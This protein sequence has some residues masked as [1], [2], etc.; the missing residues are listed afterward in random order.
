MRTSLLKALLGVTVSLVIV[1]VTNVARADVLE[2]FQLRYNRNGNIPECV[3]LWGGVPNNGAMA[4]SWSCKSANAAQDQAWYWDWSDCFT[5]TIDE[6]T[7]ETAQVCSIRN[8]LNTSKCLGIDGGSRSAGAYAKVWD[9]LGK[10]HL[11]QY[12][13]WD[14][15]ASDT[16]FELWNYNNITMGLGK[17]AVVQVSGTSQDAEGLTPQ[18]IDF[19]FTPAQ[20]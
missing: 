11:D 5:V 9:C 17:V 20:P 2:G 1:S 3:G 18:V 7:G 10:S 4:I 16:V 13:L 6:N 8:G 14:G 12:W 19:S 15:N